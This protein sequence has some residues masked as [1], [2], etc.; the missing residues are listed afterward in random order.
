MAGHENFDYSFL[1]DRIEEQ[2]TSNAPGEDHEEEKEERPIVKPVS[3]KT[4][5][6]NFE[7]IRTKIDR[8]Q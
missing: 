1:L 7:S 4:A 6:T 5:W 2:M 8:T 3:V